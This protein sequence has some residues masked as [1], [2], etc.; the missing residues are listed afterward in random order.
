MNVYTD[1][2]MNGIGDS[3]LENSME[4]TYT[5]LHMKFKK[6]SSSLFNGRHQ[7]NHMF[8]ENVSFISRSSS[9]CKLICDVGYKRYYSSPMCVT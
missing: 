5:S 1:F 9:S 2:I 7:F 8:M 6:Q 4:T 3:L